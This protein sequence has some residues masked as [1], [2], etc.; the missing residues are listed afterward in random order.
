MSDKK[1]LCEEAKRLR[2]NLD[3][4]VT[5][6]VGFYAA[7]IT[8]RATLWASEDF[9]AISEFS[10]L[11]SVKSSMPSTMSL[12]YWNAQEMLEFH[13]WLALDIIL[14]SSE[15][16][17]AVVN[18][19]CCTHISPKLSDV[20]L[21]NAHIWVN[22][23][24]LSSRWCNGSLLGNGEGISFPGSLQWGHNPWGTLSPKG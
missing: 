9:R 5:T 4:F 7:G 3:V 13:C 1:E 22:D 17:C 18:D 24:V 14:T 2:I 19:N 12:K 23:V 16:I 21:V 11:S 20:F 15:C 6:W 10:M 8:E